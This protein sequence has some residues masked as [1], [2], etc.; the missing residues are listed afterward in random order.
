MYQCRYYYDINK[1]K[2]CYTGK[3]KQEVSRDNFTDI[4]FISG[5]CITSEGVLWA[6]AIKKGLLQILLDAKIAPASKYIVM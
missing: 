4:D 3:V 2:L 5:M 6:A 1:L